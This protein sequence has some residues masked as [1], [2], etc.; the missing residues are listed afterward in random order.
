MGSMGRLELYLWNYFY[1]SDRG[2]LRYTP[3]PFSASSKYLLPQTNDDKECTDFDEKRRCFKAGWL[4]KE[5]NQYLVWSILCVNN[6][7]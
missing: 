6:E 5:E 7:K 4:T 2:V 3:H 1:F